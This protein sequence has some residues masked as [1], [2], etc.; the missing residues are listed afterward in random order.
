MTI[1]ANKASIKGGEFLIKDIDASQIFIPEDFT[2]EQQMIAQTCLD[3]LRTEVHPRLDDI[4][5][6]KNTDLMV[7]L[8]DKAGE[9]GLLGTAIPEEYG[10][11]GMNFNTSMLVAEACGGGHSFSVALS[12]HTGIGTLPILYYGTEEQKAKYLPRL[13]TGE[14]KAAYCLTEPDSGSDANSG[15]TKAVLSEDGKHYIINGQKMWITNGGFAD[16]FIVFAKID[17]DKALTA[18]IV[19][20]SFGGITMNEEE[21]KMGIKG[22]S[23]RQ[24]FF[25]DCKVP[26]ENQLYTREGGF[27]IAVNI[28]NIG[29]IKLASAVVGAAKGIIGKAVN[30]ANERKQFGTSISNFGA[31]KYKIAEMN[32]KVFAS[33]SA[34]YR[35][36]QNIDDAI[37]DLLASGVESA[38]AKLKGVEQFA[39]E[40]AM[41][42]V[43]G[44]EVLDYVVDE[45]VQIYGGMGF[46]AEAP[47]DRAYRDSRINRIFEG[48]NE[49]NRLLAVGTVVKRAMKGEINLMPAA[50][51]VGKEIMSIPDFSVSDDEGI[52]VAEK[53][54]IKN[55]KKAI[56]MVAGA[57][58]QKF[59]M[60]FE[61]EQE[62]IMNLAD[63]MI[64]LYIAESTL[65][66]VEKLIAVRGEAACA[67]HKDAALI[68]L[69]TAVE[70]TNNAGKAAITSFAEGDELRVMLMGLKRFTKIEPINLKEA[71]RRVAE[72]AI[73][74]NS[75]VF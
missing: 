7:S 46:S 34:C 75:Y 29:R 41:L 20:K 27:K 33:E 13:A 22:S 73:E 32:V 8:M 19:E 42:K 49:I 62:I 72:A 57:A 54:V 30:Y 26:V 51:E 56:L 16:L 70:K 66:R 28:L 58:L 64:E 65:L 38:Q 2:E 45:G 74:K 40:C 53:K 69:H 4:D 3:F 17:N 31:I 11:F 68:Y 36:G 39:I 6:A 63:M 48:T 35:A 1:T 12:A 52:F 47:M 44:S 5:Y 60:K 10:G 15:K 43:H 24:I 55:L 67:L 18:F 14:W 50:M 71:R 21:R 23:T 59:M 61:Q 37:E 25:N 9:L